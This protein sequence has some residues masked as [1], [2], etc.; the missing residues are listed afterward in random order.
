MEIVFISRYVC[1]FLITGS[2]LELS[3]GKTL[4][5]INLS[6]FK[7]PNKMK[8]CIASVSNTLDVKVISSDSLT[9]TS[10]LPESTN[11]NGF[12]NLSCPLIEFGGCGNSRLDLISV[13]PSCWIKEMEVK[14]EEIVCIY[15][16]PKTS[17]KVQGSYC[18]LMIL[19]TILTDT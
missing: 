15:D 11:C 4:G 2:T 1:P 9:D 16:F 14:V 17:N 12:N 3:Q 19:I 13:F 10:I 5:E 7:R 18:V 8:A 6:M